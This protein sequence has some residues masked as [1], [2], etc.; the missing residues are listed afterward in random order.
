MAESDGEGISDIGRF[1]RCSQA[2][3][4]GNGQLY[5][6]LTG[7]A[8]A[9]DQ[10][11]HLRGTVAEGGNVPQACCQEHYSAGM[12]HD[13][14]SA[15]MLVVGIEL[16]NGHGLWLKLIKDFQ[17]TLMQ[18]AKSDFQGTIATPQYTCFA[19]LW[20]VPGDIQN[21]VASDAQTRID[22]EDALLHGWYGSR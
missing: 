18:G 21:R 16:F 14:G 3:F 11:F 13:D 17:Q 4:L 1:R 2:H 12:A 8:C 15:G 22:A 6:F 9:T 7:P 10:L 19:E 20:P 5:L